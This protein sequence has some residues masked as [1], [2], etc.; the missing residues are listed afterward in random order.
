MVT[1]PSYDQIADAIA[2]CL[3]A[4]LYE[5]ELRQDGQ[6]VP[7]PVWRL[8]RVLERNGLIDAAAFRGNGRAARASNRW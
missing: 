5:L 3:A 7:D 1:R 2:A 4:G 6:P 8:A